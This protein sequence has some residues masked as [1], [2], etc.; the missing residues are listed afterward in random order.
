LALLEDQEVVFIVVTV[1]SN[2]ETKERKRRER[3]K[4][5]MSVEILS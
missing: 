4:T 1:D 3:N 5:H 2:R